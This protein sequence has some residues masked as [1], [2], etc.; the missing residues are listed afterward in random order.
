LTRVVRVILSMDKKRAFLK[1]NA[2][3]ILSVAV[4]G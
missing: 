3:S 4:W 2:R 1:R